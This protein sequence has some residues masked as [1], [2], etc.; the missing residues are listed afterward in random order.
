[1]RSSTSYGCYQIKLRKSCEIQI[2]VQQQEDHFSFQLSR[3]V[4]V[5]IGTLQENIPVN[6]ET[7]SHFIQKGGISLPFFV[8]LEWVFL[9]HLSF[10]TTLPYLK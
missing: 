4:N 8:L 5:P 2:K 3:V 7:D 6:R 9:A 10:S 1:M